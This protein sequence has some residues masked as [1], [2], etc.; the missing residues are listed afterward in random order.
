MD[1]FLYECN[2]G[3]IQFNIEIELQSILL[4]LAHLTCQ[5]ILNW[6]LIFAF[7]CNAKSFAVACIVFSLSSSRQCFWV[8]FE[9]F[10]TYVLETVTQ[11]VWQVPG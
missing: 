5:M 1:W 2:I 4:L 3:L 9:K 8:D 11:R 7:A 6:S 10:F